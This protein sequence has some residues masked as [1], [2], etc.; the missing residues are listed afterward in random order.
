[1]ISRETLKQQLREMGILPGDTVLVHTALRSVGPVEGGADGF[2][3]ALLEYLS[4]G[5]LLIPT[6]TWADVNRENPVYDVRSSVPCIGTV[7]KIA[8]FRSD[9]IRSL[10]PTHSMAVFDGKTA[11]G[12]PGPAEEYI[13]GEERVDTSTSHKGC[14]GKL[15][16]RNGKVLL[17]GVGHNRNTYLHSVEERMDVPNRLSKDPVNIQIRLRSGTVIDRPIRCHQAVGIGDASARYPK[18]EPAFRQ[19]GAIT[20]GKIGHAEVQ[21]CD[22][23]K[24]AEVMALVRERSGGRELLTEDTPL[25]KA[26]Y[27]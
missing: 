23:R 13:A 8:A 9:G 22:A 5:L 12:E 20:D 25:E 4:D 17:I 10:H 7:P 6:H 24:M 27:E 2:I 14:Y 3:D 1:L 26:L 19:H 11:A 15:Y 18:Y 21:L 16:E